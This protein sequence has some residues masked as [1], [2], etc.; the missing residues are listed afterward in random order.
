MCK[1][2]VADIAL[3]FEQYYVNAHNMRSGYCQ[4][5]NLS[6]LRKIK[7]IDGNLFPGL[8]F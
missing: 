7:S 3:L 6:T 1:V 5:I 4:K 8:C 2:T